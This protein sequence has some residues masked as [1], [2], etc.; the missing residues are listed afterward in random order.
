MPYKLVDR[1]GEPELVDW[2]K[3]PSPYADSLW[4][5]FGGIGTGMILGWLIAIA[6]GLA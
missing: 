1:F 3:R 4:M 2:S 5:W 6:A